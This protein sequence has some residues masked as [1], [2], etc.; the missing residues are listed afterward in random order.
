VTFPVGIP[1]IFV[2][3]FSIPVILHEIYF[4]YLRPRVK[5]IRI[6]RWLFVRY[7]LPQFDL[8]G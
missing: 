5:F 7:V 4:W 1:G 3:C 6:G 8:P 2:L